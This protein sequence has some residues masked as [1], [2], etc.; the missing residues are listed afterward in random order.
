MAEITTMSGG[1]LVNELAV[2]NGT[3]KKLRDNY[4][5]AVKEASD[6][7]AKARIIKIQISQ[8][9]DEIAACKYA[10]KAEAA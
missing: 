2:L 9:R 4:Q 6:S 10:I 3:L 8:L 1:E 7:T 5:I